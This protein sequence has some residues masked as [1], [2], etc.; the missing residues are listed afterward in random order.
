MLCL[1]ICTPDIGCPACVAICYVFLQQYCC[2]PYVPSVQPIQIRYIVLYKIEKKTLVADLIAYRPMLQWL[3]HNMALS[4]TPKDGRIPC[5]RY[6][7]PQRLPPSLPLKR[8]NTDGKNGRH[9]GGTSHD[10]PYSTA[11]V[12]PLPV[13]IFVFV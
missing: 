3:I 10:A 11:F 9:L 1:H 7:Q 6:C 12:F 4:L 5:I 2:L 8:I 13:I